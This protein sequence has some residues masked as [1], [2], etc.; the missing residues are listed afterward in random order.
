[1]RTRS[2]S[3]IPVGDLKGSS[4]LERG[5]GVARREWICPAR[6]KERIVLHIFIK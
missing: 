1:M 3:N 5:C 6:C 4:W 2:T